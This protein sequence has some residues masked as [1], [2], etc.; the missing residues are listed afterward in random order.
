MIG[1]IIAGDD[2]DDVEAADVQLIDALINEISALH[3]VCDETNA[4][5]TI[6]DAQIEKLDEKVRSFQRSTMAANKEMDKIEANHEQ[7]VKTVN[8]QLKRA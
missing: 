8:N 6:M 2:L 4:R 3:K 7:Y 1:D 5:I